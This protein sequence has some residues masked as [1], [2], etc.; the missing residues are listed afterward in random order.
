MF[1]NDLIKPKGKE[2]TGIA[3]VTGFLSKD[4]EVSNGF[5]WCEENKKRQGKVFIMLLS[6]TFQNILHLKVKSPGTSLVV[7]W[8]RICHP[9]HSTRG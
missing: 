4:D 3:L 2:M 1:A 5:C 9:M 8:L 6:R 7:Q